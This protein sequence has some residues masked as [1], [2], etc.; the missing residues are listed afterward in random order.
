MKK[1]VKKNTLSKALRYV[2]KYKGYLILSLF[3]P[4]ELLCG[5]IFSLSGCLVMAK[6]PK[7]PMTNL[8]Q[9]AKKTKVK[10]LS[11]N[12][13]TIGRRSAIICGH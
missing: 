9:S 12:P 13:L 10:K 5:S 11:K 8:C 4:A 1:P 3:G 6:M 2:G 7:R